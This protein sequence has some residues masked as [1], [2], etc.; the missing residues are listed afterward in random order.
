MQSMIDCERYTSICDY[1]RGIWM[2]QNA[3]VRGMEGMENFLHS[4]CEKEKSKFSSR[5]GYF[6]HLPYCKIYQSSILYCR[7]K[8]RELFPAR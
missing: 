7:N 4:I 6:F 5:S 2:S 3:L 8:N 1:L